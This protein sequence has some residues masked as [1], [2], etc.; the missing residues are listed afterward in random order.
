[1]ILFFLFVILFS[2][3]NHRLRLYPS[4][5]DRFS[6]VSVHG[7]YLGCSVIFLCSNFLDAIYILYVRLN[8]IVQ[9]FNNLSFLFMFHAGWNCLLCTFCAIYAGG[10]NFFKIAENLLNK[11]WCVL[12]FRNM[13]IL[14]FNE[15]RPYIY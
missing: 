2:F 11:F 3:F 13:W 1:M 8:F 10:P 5:S 15:L 9:L 14:H 4:T 7:N 6:L 12:D